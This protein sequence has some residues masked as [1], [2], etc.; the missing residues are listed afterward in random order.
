[1]FAAFFAANVGF[2]SRANRFPRPF[3]IAGY[4][5]FAAYFAA[6]MGIRAKAR[7]VFPHLNQLNPTNPNPIK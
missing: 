4:P 6:K 3:A 2:L 5:I 7:T 1:M